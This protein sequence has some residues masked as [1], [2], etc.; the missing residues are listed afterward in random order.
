VLHV[1]NTLTT[2]K[3]DK[4]IKR[5][6]L[7]EAILLRTASKALSGHGPSSRLFIKEHSLVI[8]EHSEVHD[9]YFP[10]LEHMEIYFVLNSKTY[11][12]ELSRKRLNGFRKLTR[13]T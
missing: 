13:R 9:K 2:V 3:T 5:I 10:I 7:I 12:D 11:Q 6:T 8:Q 4:G 1:G